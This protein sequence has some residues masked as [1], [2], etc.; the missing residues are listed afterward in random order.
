MLFSIL[1]D[2]ANEGYG[3]WRRREPFRPLVALPSPTPTAFSQGDTALPLPVP[4]LMLRSWARRWN[5]FWPAC[6]F[7]EELL[8]GFLPRVGLAQAQLGTRTLDLCPGK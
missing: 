8:T 7:S 2:L 5:E 1:L 6:S 4:E 3:W